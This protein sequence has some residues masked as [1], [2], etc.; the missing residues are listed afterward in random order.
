MPAVV[1]G[2][3]RAGFL[4][5]HRSREN[6]EALLDFLENAAVE[7]IVV[8]AEVAEDY[9]AL[10]RKG[11]PLPTNDVWIAACAARSGAAVLTFDEHFRQVE[12]VGCLVLEEEEDYPPARRHSR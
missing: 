2:E 10:R 5:G 1:L 6:V 7:E 8:D 11:R 9:A 12:R 3:L 4:R